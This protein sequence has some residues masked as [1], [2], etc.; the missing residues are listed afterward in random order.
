MKHKQPIPDPLIAQLL[1]ESRTQAPKDLSGNVMQRIAMQ[2]KEAKLANAGGLP[3][4][5]IRQGIGITVGIFAAMTGLIYLFH[6]PLPLSVHSGE[7]SYYV[8]LVTLVG[9][10]GAFFFLKELSDY[11]LITHHQRMHRG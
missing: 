4:K 2:E 1:K 6:R 7:T 9:I 5:W 11:L 10:G 3:E 8:V